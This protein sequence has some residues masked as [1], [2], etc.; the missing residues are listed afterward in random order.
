MFVVIIKGNNDLFITT[1]VHTV[2][3]EF[4]WATKGEKD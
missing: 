2:T 1:P 3:D 4:I